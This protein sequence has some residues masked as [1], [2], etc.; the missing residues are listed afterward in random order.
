MSF[1]DIQNQIDNGIPLITMP[2]DNHFEV[3]IGYAYDKQLGIEIV[4]C[5]NSQYPQSSNNYLT[6]Y[7]F[8]DIKSVATMTFNKISN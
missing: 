2:E 4:L 8:N 1:E 3:I 6:T 7:S 5:A